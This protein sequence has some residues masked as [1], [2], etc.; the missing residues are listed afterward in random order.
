VKK[1]KYVSSIVLGKML[2]KV[3][4]GD[5]YNRKYLRAA[6]IGWLN[7]NVE[8][9]K[10]MWFSSA[11]LT[12]LRLNEFDLLVSEGGEVGRTCIWRNELDECYIQNSV[13]KITF[14]NSNNPF[15]FLYQ[16][17]LYG[18]K[19]AFDSIVNRIGIAHLTVEKIRDID[20]PVSPLKEQTAIVEYI[21]AEIYRINTK[22][23]KTKKLIELL[24]EYKQALISEVVTGKIKVI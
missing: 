12:K 7:F 15:Y 19:G 23:E 14:I 16:F 24:K 17:Y 5:F 22:A 6:N 3:D 9:V 2:T 4:K 18:K 8:D 13:H 21:E 10:K 11:E 1:L 20:F